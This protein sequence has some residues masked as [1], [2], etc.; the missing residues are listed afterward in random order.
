METLLSKK[1][2]M[3]SR[4]SQTEDQSLPVKKLKSNSLAKDN[5]SKG[6]KQ[7]L[8]SKVSDDLLTLKPPRI[9]PAGLH[10]EK[11]WVR[12]VEDDLFELPNLNAD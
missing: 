9:D 12:K 6:S 11:F 1:V 3:E 7:R 2:I 4:E 10:S 5:E 8:P